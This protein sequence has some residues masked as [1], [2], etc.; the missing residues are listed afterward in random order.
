M[1]YIWQG[2][3][4]EELRGIYCTDT[5]DWHCYTKEVLYLQRNAFAW[6]LAE[7]TLSHHTLHWSSLHV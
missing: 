2:Q 7:M 6:L 1:L 3:K 4:S 5:T